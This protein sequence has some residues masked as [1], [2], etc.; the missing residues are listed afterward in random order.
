VQDGKDMNIEAQEFL[1]EAAT[2]Q[3]APEGAAHWE[4][5][6]CAVVICRVCQL[7]TA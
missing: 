5:V 4:D 2:K 3:Q 6:A 7:V 1:L